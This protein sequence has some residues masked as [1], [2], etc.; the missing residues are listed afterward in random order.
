MSSRTGKTAFQNARPINF[1]GKRNSLSPDLHCINC[2]LK[3]SLNQAKKS[4]YSSVNA[5]FGKASRIA[6]EEVVIKL[7]VRVCRFC[8]VV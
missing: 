1:M 7:K 5:I 4:F 2:T 8:F 6:T 3:C